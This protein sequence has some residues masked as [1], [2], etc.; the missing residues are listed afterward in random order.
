MRTRNARDSVDILTK[1][2]LICKLC[3]QEKAIIVDRS[4]PLINV[5]ALESDGKIKIR[6]CYPIHHHPDYC[7]YHLKEKGLI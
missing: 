6:R 5:N 4:K 1:L 2:N 7:S 3:T